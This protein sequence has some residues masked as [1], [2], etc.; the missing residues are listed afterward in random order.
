MMSA[1]VERL[2]GT[3]NA[4]ASVLFS[5]VG[6]GLYE[7]SGYRS[8]PA[9]DWLLPPSE[10][11]NEVQWLPASAPPARLS[12]SS[13]ELVLH[14]SAEQFDWHFERSRLYARYLGRKPLEHWGARTD[15]ASVWWTASYKADELL[16]LRLEAPSALAARR[17][18]QA[19]Q[20]QARAAGFKRVRVWE[21]LSLLGI[22]GAERVRRNGELPM[23]AGLG[24]A[25]KGWK[26]V[27]RGLWV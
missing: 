10:L 26:Q 21:T 11:A 25:V 24:P 9:F 12:D 6:P 19:A 4:Q 14:P 20:H 16:V 2:A 17:V 3:P 5:D 13:E 18:L 7:R 27:E 8:V 1:L 23:V 22:P 15:D